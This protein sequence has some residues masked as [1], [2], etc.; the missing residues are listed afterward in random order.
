MKKID[1]DEPMFMCNCCGDLFPR[2]EMDFDIELYG[3][4]ELC[5]FDDEPKFM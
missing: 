5:N 4:A 2:D 1:K 3:I